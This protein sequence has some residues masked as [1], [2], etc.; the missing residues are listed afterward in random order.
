MFSLKDQ[1]KKLPVTWQIEISSA[2]QTFVATT[3]GTLLLSLSSSGSVSFSRDA[4]AGLLGAALRS[5]LKAVQNGGF[6]QHTIP[7]PA[8]APSIPPVTPV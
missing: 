8:T 7:V 6:G 3:A 4:I 2:V 5:G 1:W